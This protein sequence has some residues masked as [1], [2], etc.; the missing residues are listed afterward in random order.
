MYEPKRGRWVSKDPIQRLQGVYDYASDTPVRYIDPSGL[1]P[2]DGCPGDT[3]LSH[4]T[5]DQVV[6]RSRKKETTKYYSRYKTRLWTDADEIDP[7]KKRDQAAYEVTVHK[8]TVSV[9]AS[10]C[11]TD[12]KGRCTRDVIVGISFE[13]TLSAIRRTRNYRLVADSG[14]FDP[15]TGAWYAATKSRKSPKKGVRTIYI[16][17][18]QKFATFSCRDKMWS[19]TMHYTLKSEKDKKRTHQDVATHYNSTITVSTAKCG[20]TITATYQLS[21]NNAKAASLEGK[22]LIELKGPNDKRRAPH[23]TGQKA[24]GLE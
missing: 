7:P 1:F 20:M 11:K 5:W 2:T 10:N 23:K 6:T 9:D 15:K 8:Y 4:L 16:A 18:A 14:I 24:I 22:R 19:G 13:T 17:S 3:G 12:R 21:L